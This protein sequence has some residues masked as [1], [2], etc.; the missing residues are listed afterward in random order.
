MWYRNHIDLFKTDKPVTRH[1]PGLEWV[2]CTGAMFLL[3]LPQPRSY[4]GL[5]LI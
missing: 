1:L 5:L 2:F 3:F 4:A